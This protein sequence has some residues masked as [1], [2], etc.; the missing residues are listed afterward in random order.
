MKILEKECDIL[1]PAAI[2][3]S[4]SEKNVDKLKCKVI[5]EAAN[6][7]TTYEAD[8]KLNERGIIV[9][10]DLV[11]NAGGV[12]VSYFEW[13]KNIDHKEMG[14]LTRRWERNSKQ[15]LFKL[16]SSDKDID[17]SNIPNLDGASEKNIVYSGL[18]EIMCKTVESMFDLAH[19]E[20][21]SYRIAAYK[22]S[23]N[24]VARVYET[25]GLGI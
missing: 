7:P 9:L 24:K 1:I 18:E 5:A 19:K 13:L 22:I 3:N 21:L 12:T 6:G 15:H 17:I 25:A 23:I 11:M 14:L 8:K 10:P 16:L 4:I 2:E 20:N